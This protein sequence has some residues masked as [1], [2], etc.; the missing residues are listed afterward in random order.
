VLSVV[1]SVLVVAWV[2]S[3]W[4]TADAVIGQPLN[5]ETNRNEFDWSG[6]PRNR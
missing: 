3:R 4:V 1:V 5:S 6:I 2:G